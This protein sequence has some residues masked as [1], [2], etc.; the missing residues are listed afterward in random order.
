MSTTPIRTMIKF[1]TTTYKDA[2]KGSYKDMIIREG[3]FIIITDIPWWRR[4]FGLMASRRIVIGDGKT[5]LRKL[6]FS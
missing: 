5:P 1:T 4:C 2:K 6:K 3:T